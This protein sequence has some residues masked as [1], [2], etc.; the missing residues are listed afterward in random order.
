M[1]TA[2]SRGTRH[3]VLEMTSLALGNGAATAWPFTGG[4]FTNLTRDHLDI[5]KTPEHYL[6]SKAQLFVHLQPQGFAVLNGDDPASKLLAEIIRPSVRIER[7]GFGRHC[8]AQL[9]DVGVSWS[10]TAVRMKDGQQLHVP[11][12]GKHFGENAVAAWLAAQNMGVTAEAA[13]QRLA[14]AEVPRGRF[15]RV[16]QGPHVVSD[17]AHSPDAMQKTLQTARE[18]A[19][20]ARVYVVFGASAGTDPKHRPLLAKAASAADHVIITNDNPR[21]EDPSTIAKQLASGMSGRHFEVVLDRRAAIARAL[22][23]ANRDD[24]VIL[25]GRGHEEIQT[26]GDATYYGS[27]AAIARALLGGISS[28]ES[29]D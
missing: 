16:W 23:Q 15:E 22:E 3:A 17:Y 20:N 24:I 28:A 12:I 2:F 7:Y 21:D 9:Q 27:D 5:H 25:A 29:Q 4:V 14:E 10:G 26:V 8:E 6:A 13:A 19:G 11:L 18:L 1:R